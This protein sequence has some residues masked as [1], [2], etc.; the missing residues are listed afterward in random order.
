MIAESDYAQRI[1]RVR[2]QM[3][4]KGIEVLIVTPG[5]DLSYL[6]GYHAVPLERLTALVV[7]QDRDPFLVVPRLELS[8]ALAS[9]FGDTG[10]EVLP[11]GEND[12]P[13]HVIQDRLNTVVKRLAVDS[14]MW[15]ERVLKIQDTFQQAHILTAGELI[16]ELRMRKTALE[17]DYLREAAA[18]I[19]RV[20]GRI[21]EILRVGRTEREVGK[22]I[23]DMI[24]EEGHDRVDFI[25]VASGPNAASPHHELSDRVLQHGDPVVIDIGGTMPSGYCSDCTRTYSLGVP[26]EEFLMRYQV[27]QRAQQ[28][29]TAAVRE[30]ALSHDI[31]KA[32]RH[33]L[34]EHGLG[35]YFIHRTG[36]GIGL[37]THEEPYIGIDNPTV[38]RANMVFSIEPGFY[39]DGVYGARI[40][41]IVI[42]TS[43]GPESINKQSHDLVIVGQ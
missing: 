39:I 18:A 43:L 28:L 16:T 27:L 15:A 40:E 20:H 12:D 24:I 1:D 7:T 30:G 41:D 25:I 5:A 17:L 8:T 21:P 26:D 36:H 2:E 32:G 37:E 23:A 33:E 3:V 6:V 42:C 31:D 11:W 38:I 22:D 14:H 4:S 34:A 35:E 9:P 19:D 10:W 29:S 13:Y